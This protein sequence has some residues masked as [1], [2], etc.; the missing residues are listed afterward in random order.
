MLL[1]QRL[2]HDEPPFEALGETGPVVA[3]WC[4][5]VNPL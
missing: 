2:H 5:Q 3:I 4:Q 1:D